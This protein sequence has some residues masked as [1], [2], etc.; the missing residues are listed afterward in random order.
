MDKPTFDYPLYLN[1]KGKTCLVVGGGQVAARKIKRLLSSAASVTVLA[2]Q[3]TPALN[4]LVSSGQLI[5]K[6]QLFIAGET[7]GFFLV[8]A[9]TD[10]PAT[11]ALVAA[12]ANA[13]GQLCNIT[14]APEQ[15]NCITPGL[16][17]QGLLHFTVSAGGSAALSKA[18]T[19]D[20]RAYYNEDFI[21]FAAFISTQREEVKLLFTT[22]PEREALWRQLLTPEL[23]QLVHTGHLQQAKERVKYAI[24]GFRTQS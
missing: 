7:A 20:L 12:E 4:A 9:A 22:S 3:L 11:N 23:L 19:A 13:H 17:R 15:G 16:V 6:K 5:W 24:D 2:P 10:K 18:L 1:L 8:I 14:S 21:E